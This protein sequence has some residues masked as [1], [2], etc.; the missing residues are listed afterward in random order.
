MTSRVQKLQQKGKGGIKCGSISNLGNRNEEI[1]TMK[2][3]IGTNKNKS[4]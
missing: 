4:G 2:I 3:N 1:L